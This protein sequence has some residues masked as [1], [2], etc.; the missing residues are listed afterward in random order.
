MNVTSAILPRLNAAP[1]PTPPASA[2][3]GS[4]TSADTVA[5]SEGAF[6]DGLSGASRF[7][8]QT[9]GMLGG[10]FFG[11][12]AAAMGVAGIAALAGVTT[13]AGVPTLAA[14]GALAVGTLAGAFAGGWMLG[15]ASDAAGNL[16]AKLVSK[17]GGTELTGQT[18]GKT[19]L[20]LGLAAPISFTLASATGA[21]IIIGGAGLAAAFIL[22][23][24]A[25][26]KAYHWL[27]DKIRS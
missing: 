17:I 21:P 23:A 9:V 1:A 6:R 2:S 26:N 14:I 27:A 24:G 5:A 12:G 18:V 13:M 22:T 10:G 15:K 3:P 19:A 25:A 16:G 7:V 4:T 8:T 11:A 20:A